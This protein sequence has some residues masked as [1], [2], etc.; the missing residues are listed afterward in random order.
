MF[1]FSLLTPEKKVVADVEVAEV[2]VPAFRGELDLLPGHLPLVT[3]LRLG[4]LRYRLKSSADFHKVVV[5][6]GYCEVGPQG[7]SV[8]AETAETIDEIDKDRAEASLRKA[9]KRIVD[10]SLEPNQVI[11]LQRKV[12]RAQARLSLLAKNSDH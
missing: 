12:E 3:T 1:L 4:V 10:P 9:L 8:L 6:W 5:S 2:I 7:V 11:K